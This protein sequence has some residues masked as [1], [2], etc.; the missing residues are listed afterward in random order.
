ML[1]FKVVMSSAGGLKMVMANFSK[2][3]SPI[4]KINAAISS[5]M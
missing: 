2:I 4:N 5:Q 1:F 3:F